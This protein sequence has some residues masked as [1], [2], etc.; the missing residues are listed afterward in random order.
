MSLIRTYILHYS[1]IKRRIDHWPHIRMFRWEIKVCNKINNSSKLFGSPNNQI[2]F[3]KLL[4]SFVLHGLIKYNTIFFVLFGLIPEMITLKSSVP[5]NF[6]SE[7]KIVFLFNA[8]VSLQLDLYLSDQNL[9]I[10]YYYI[11]LYTKYSSWSLGPLVFD[12]ENSKASLPRFSLNQYS[13]T[14]VPCMSILPLLW[15]YV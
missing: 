3:S 5:Q 8:V 9:I 1:L 14:K 13:W 12:Y 4:S 10:I 15:F 6:T 11:W 7:T 2:V